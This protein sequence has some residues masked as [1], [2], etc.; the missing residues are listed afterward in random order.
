MRL[1]L[2]AGLSAISMIHPGAAA[3]AVGRVD[4]LFQI[5]QLEYSL[6]KHGTNALRFNA[7]GWVGGDYN[8]LW[9]NTQGS[10]L[11]NGS[12]ED[13]DVQALYGRLVSPFWDLQA[14]LRYL[15]PRAEG[16]KRG[17]AV[18]GIQGL[19]PYWFDVQAA[20][21]VSDRG[22]LSGRAEVEYELLLTQ[23]LVL[24]PRMETDVAVQQVKELGIGSG[25]NSL[26]LGLRL[27]YEIRREFAP[28]IGVSWQ[29]QFG[30]TAALARARGDDIRSLG[31]IL[32]LRAWF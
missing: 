18:F 31:L 6:N 13:T 21:F 9:V 12:L 20:G 1:L 27:R 26:E 2:L 14:G 8:R 23:R 3:A 28:Y 17:T 15:Y 19:A 30:E 5:D 7:L 10:R 4:S 25:I 22:E 16:S 11:N 29:R 24:Q 32:G